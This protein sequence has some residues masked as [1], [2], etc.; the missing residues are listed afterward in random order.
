MKLIP[1]TQGLF[2]Q[3]DDEDYDDLSQYKWH[4]VKAPYTY[5]VVRAI[6]SPDKNSKNR[7]IKLRMHR[8]IMNPSNEMEVDHRDGN[9]LNNQKSNLRV[10][11]PSQNMANRRSAG[12]SRYL[13]VS[14]V[15]LFGGKYKAI[16]ASIRIGSVV[17][18]LGQY[19]TEELAAEAY[20]IA[21]WVY[22]G[23]FANLN[24]KE[25]WQSLT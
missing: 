3:V 22:H 13:G 12:R 23:E 14:I 10:C 20:D 6:T 15:Y 25:T 5:Y 1:L 8:V 17:L 19:P 24:F 18:R 2:T 4:V 11:T 21:A 16:R 9:G 7:Q